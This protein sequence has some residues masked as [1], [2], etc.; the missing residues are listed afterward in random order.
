MNKSYS[1]VLKK[2]AFPDKAGGT[3]RWITNVD[4]VQYVFNTIK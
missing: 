3:P 2:T 4:N 1:A